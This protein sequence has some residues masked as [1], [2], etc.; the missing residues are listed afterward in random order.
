MRRKR[1]AVF[2]AGCAFTNK[3]PEAMVLTVAS[4]IR[5]RFPCTDIFVHI[6]SLYF[7]Q[8]RLKGLIPLKGD[9]PTSATARLL[10]KIRM[11][12]AYYRSMA[13]VDLGGYQF[14]DPW[15][16][17]CAWKKLSSMG[18]C[19]R[20]G[21]PIFFLP[22]TWGPFS[23]AS[24]RDAV[25]CIVGLAS[26]VYT[27][28]KTSLSLVEA[29]IGGKDAKV[30]FAHDVAWNFKGADLSVGQKLL[31][32]T[33]LPIKDNS[34]KVCVTPN[35][36]VYER[37]EGIGLENKYIRS[38][39]DIINHLC[40]KHSAQV[41]L[42][43]HELRLNNSQ[44]QDDRVLCNYLLASVDKSLPI[45]HIDKY[46]PAAEV[47]SVIGNCD[48]LISSRYHG[49]IAGLSQ[50]IPSIAIG[51]AH[52]YDELFSEFNISSNLLSLSQSTEEILE[53]I[54]VIIK[55]LPQLRELIL[56]KVEVMKKSGQQAIDEV[57]TRIE[58][59]LQ[60]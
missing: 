53:G 26:L 25:R 1:N 38:L 10:S 51:W 52:K 50:G 54:D 56:P 15:G 4:A 34:L 13:L 22:Q 35:L 8:A 32:Q 36:R 18:N 33:G 11:A 2:I 59:R 39:R 42:M 31:K 46:L 6:P 14:G 5:D 30:R 7:K 49:L 37:S 9:P 24:L 16:D 41:V 20:F 17:R 12:R 57:L 27:R 45:V 60:D 55:Q 44:I 47:K 28:D 19:A 29:L 43:G 3:G 40:S 23:S 48:L 58:E 21:N